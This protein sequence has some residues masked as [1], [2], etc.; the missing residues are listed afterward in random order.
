V[1]TVILLVSTTVVNLKNSLLVS[2]ATLMIQYPLYCF[3][4]LHARRNKGTLN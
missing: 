3:T 1:C 2:Y 4:A